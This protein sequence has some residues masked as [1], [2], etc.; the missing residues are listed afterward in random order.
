[1]DL[2][3]PKKKRKF[4]ESPEDVATVIGAKVR[5]TEEGY[6]RLIPEGEEENSMERRKKYLATKIKAK[7]KKAKKVA[8]KKKMATKARAKS[9]AQK[10][11]K[12]AANGV[13]TN[14]KTEEK[15]NTKKESLKSKKEKS[16]AKKSQVKKGK[17]GLK[18][19]ANQVKKSTKS[20]AAKS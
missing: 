4:Q 18:Q 20:K 7:Q 10:T 1:M 8:L 13:K 14:A 9:A 6:I 5:V 16:I 11:G 19:P 3:A 12:V 17:T 2:K 15:L